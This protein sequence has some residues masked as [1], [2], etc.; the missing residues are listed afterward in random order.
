[1]V[2]LLILSQRAHWRPLTRSLAKTIHQSSI[3]SCGDVWLDR[4][5]TQR[6][7]TSTRPH[8]WWPRRKDEEVAGDAALDEESTDSTD[9]SLAEDK[10]LY[11]S[12]SHS[13]RHEALKRIHILGAG[14]LGAFVAHSLAGIPNRPPITLLLRRRQLRVWEHHDCSIEIITRGMKETRRG[15]EAEAVRRLLE[16]PSTPVGNR[17]GKKEGLSNK[18]GVEVQED[19]LTRGLTSKTGAVPAVNAPTLEESNPVADDSLQKNRPGIRIASKESLPGASEPLTPETEVNAWFAQAEQE[20][21]EAQHKEKDMT[22][23]EQIRIP[24]EQEEM[25]HHLIVSVKAPQTVKAIQAVAHRLTQD[26]SI[27]FLQNGMGMIDEVNKKLFPDEKY[28]PTYIVG[29]VSHGLYSNRPFSVVHA[30][31]GTIAL[32]VLP[33]VPIGESIKLEA[34]NRLSPSARYLMRTMTRTAVFVAVGFSPTDILQQQLDKLAV[35]CIINPLTAI[36]DCKNGA[37]LY[38][39]YFQ[40]VVRLLLAEISVVIKSLP[41]LSNVPN[42]NMRFD[43]LRLERMVFLIANTTA[44]N[45]SSMV[46]DIRS[47]RLTEIDYINGY[48]VQRGEEMGIH[49]VMN[50]MLMHMVKGKNK[51]TYQENADLLPL[52]GQRS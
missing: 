47:G 19:S 42:V 14:N 12:H 33:R 27:L 10:T 16:D 32:G 35:N 29:V 40:R 41:E 21:D 52:A 46:Q 38:N 39:F 45:H 43:T 50:Y 5:V 20:V 36:L 7:F 3:W 23:P 48:I 18:T 8:Y 30:G 22:A 9:D 6:H 11:P 1:M 28:R 37:L 51:N 17:S 25:I 34:L 2:T 4:A 44:E 15:F 26:S 49:C 24:D 13:R 31:E